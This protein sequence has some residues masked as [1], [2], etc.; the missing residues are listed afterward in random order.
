MAHSQAIGRSPQFLAIYELPLG[1]FSILTTWLLDFP[2]V[3][4]QG[5]REGERKKV[6]ERESKKEEALSAFYNLVSEVTYFYHILLHEVSHS[7]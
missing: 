7:V 3:S 1:P 6:G 4:D 2:R 5:E